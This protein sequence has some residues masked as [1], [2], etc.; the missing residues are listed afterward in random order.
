MLKYSASAIGSLRCS[1]YYIV[2]ILESY[3]FISFVLFIIN[4]FDFS[5]LQADLTTV[6]IINVNLLCFFFYDCSLFFTTFRVSYLGFWFTL[7]HKIWSKSIRPTYGWGEKKKPGY[8]FWVGALI[9][10][11]SKLLSTYTVYF[12]RPRI[13]F[14]KSPRDVVKLCDVV[15]FCSTKDCKIV[16]RR[17]PDDDSTRNN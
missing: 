15:K 8:I 4:N 13:L 16:N 1:T 7:V 9:P 12:I 14:I 6:D 2:I 11:R 10:S 3:I 5:V 17:D